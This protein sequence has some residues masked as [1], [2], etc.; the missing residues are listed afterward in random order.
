MSNTSARKAVRL[1]S[2]NRCEARVECN[3]AEAVLFHHRKR[4]PHLAGKVDTAAVLLH[5]CDRCHA[6]IH[7]NP[8]KSYSLGLLVHSWADP[9]EVPWQW[10]AVGGIVTE[11]TLMDFGDPPELVI[12]LEGPTA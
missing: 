10:G 3:G 5:L 9:D 2:G 4:R 11:P 7:H 1:R 12:P 8:Q 6:W